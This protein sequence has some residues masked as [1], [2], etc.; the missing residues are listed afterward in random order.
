MIRRY[1]FDHKHAC[2]L[3]TDGHSSLAV[4]EMFG[5]SYQAVIKALKSNGISPRLCYEE[6]TGER[7][8]ANFSSRTEV[9]SATGCWIWK[10]AINSRGYGVIHTEGRQQRAHRVAWYLRH[11]V[12]PP[13]DRFVCH[14]C[15]NPKCVNPDHLFIGTGTD[16]MQDAKSK[17]R[18][19]WQRQTHC[20][21]GHELVFIYKRRRC[22][23]CDR[24]IGRHAI[25]PRSNVL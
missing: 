1:K 9:D 25:P 14:R 23:T 13:N 8:R 2:E 11:G 16:N 5:V 12:Y 3:Y 21:N 24:S 18:L 6:N 20:K 17:G 22:L 15:D 19:A 4:A 7:L 10:G